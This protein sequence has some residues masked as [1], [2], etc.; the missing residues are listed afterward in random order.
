MKKIAL[1]LLHGVITIIAL[2]ISW[3]IGGLL[4]MF[5]AEMPQPEHDP[6]QTASRFLLV[7]IINAILITALTVAT[8]K[9]RG[10][11]RW[12]FLAL[13]VF[14][15][16]FFLTQMETLFFL[17]AIGMTGAQ[18]TAVMVTGLIVA[19][20]STS[21][22][23]A[24]ERLHKKKESQIIYIPEVSTKGKLRPVL[25][26]TLVVYPVLYFAFGYFIAWQNPD[27]RLYYTGSDELRPFLSQ[28]IHEF[29]AEGIYP[30]QVLRALLWVIIS[31]PL[32]NT[33]GT[34]T[35]RIILFALLNA[36][37]PAS[38]LLLPNAFMP[39]S[40]ATSHLYETASSNFI[41]GIAIAVLLGRNR[42]LLNS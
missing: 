11:Y 13:F 26:L 12:L 15:I 41:W 9:Y 5:I 35:G 8:N 16:Q 18:V 33:M 42:F 31:L 2:F 32:V 37:I 7:T 34:T 38:M 14:G 6:A 39:E 29:I 25:I 22:S 36:L 3:T 30:F 17:D 10:F 1:V 4:G 40:V 27:L 20:I 23:V 21:A 19:L 28:F 24:A